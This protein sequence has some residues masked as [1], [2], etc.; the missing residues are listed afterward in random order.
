MEPPEPIFFHVSIYLK[1]VW[2]DMRSAC[3]MSLVELL[4]VMALIG[5]AVG[6]AALYLRP[7]EAP[8]QAAGEQLEGF[9]RQAR[10]RAMANTL[11]YRVAPGSEGALVA[12]YAANCGETTWTTDAGLVLRFPRGVTMTDTTWSACFNSRGLANANLVITLMHAEYDPKQVEILL[13][14][15][16]RVLQ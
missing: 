6:A 2:V 11:A 7:M 15:A 14:G 13:G 16:A 9:L 1:E 10:A 4:V 5:L 8:V 12:E 3:G